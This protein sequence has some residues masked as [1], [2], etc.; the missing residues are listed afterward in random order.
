MEITAFW[1]VLLCSLVEMYQ[2]FGGN[3][4]CL[5]QREKMKVKAEDGGSWFLQN[6]PSYQ[7]LIFIFTV[8]R[9]SDVS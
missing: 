4:C 7:T 3:C 8:V 5:L 2:H 6:F 9:S 1:D